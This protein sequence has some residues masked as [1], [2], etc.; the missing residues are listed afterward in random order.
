MLTSG[1]H[2]GAVAVACLLCLP[3]AAAAQDERGAV[4]SGSVHATNI[5]SHTDVGFSGTFGYRFSRVFGLEIEA[6][7]V[8]ELKGPADTFPGILDAVSTSPVGGTISVTQI[9]PA[10]VLADASG[11]LVIFTNNARIEIPT[12]SER[13]LPYFVAGGGIASTRRTAQFTYTVP[14]V[15]APSGAPSAIPVQLRTIRQPIVSASTDLALT[16]GGGVGFRVRK[17]VSVDV[18]LRLFRI[19]SYDDVNAGRFGLG[20]RYRF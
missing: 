11:R 17:R 8:P 4:V 18:D 10:P 13:V 1:K 3:A 2:T 7:A 19:L 9:F 15:A 20:V 6:T 12:I 14:N 5:D 16:I